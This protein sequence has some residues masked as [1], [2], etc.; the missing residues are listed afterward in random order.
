MRFVSKQNLKQKYKHKQQ[1]LAAS[2]PSDSEDLVVLLPL[3][4]FCWLSTSP[5]GKNGGD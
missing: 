4:I 3:P 5:A 1:G 2:F